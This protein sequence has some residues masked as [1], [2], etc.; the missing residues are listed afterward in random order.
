MQ[1]IKQFLP[2]LN[3][4]GQAARLRPVEPGNRIPKIIHQTHYLDVLPAE[5]NENIV[6]IKALN[7]GWEYRFYNDND[8]QRFISENYGPDILAYFNRINPSYGAARADLF[9]YLVVYQCGGVYLDIKST[10]TVPL[11]TVITDDD[12]FLLSYWKNKAGDEFEGFG[13][14]PELDAQK[15][16]FQ[17]WHVIGAPG[18]PFLKAVIEAVLSNI[19]TYLPSLHGV[20]QHGVV[21]LTGPVAYTLAI[22]SLLRSHACRIAGG[23]E[24]IG[25]KYSIYKKYSHM[26]IAKAGHYTVLKDSIILL[27]PARKR[28]SEGVRRLQKINDET[29][30]FVKST[31]HK[32]SGKKLGNK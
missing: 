13:I 10:L 5:I 30:D 8:I 16:E 26:H 25:L 15:G 28:L 21:R 12:A 17:Q 23:E 1:F 31:A 9:R 7:P 18:H 20:G 3:K 22:N 11:D 24:E 4:P 2:K 19:D 14:H 29:Q 32:I 27:S 6:K